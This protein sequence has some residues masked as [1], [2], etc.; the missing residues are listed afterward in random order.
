MISR[1]KTLIIAAAA[2]LSVVG[3]KSALAAP[4]DVTNQIKV[5]PTTNQVRWS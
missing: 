2:V 5:T 4:Q 1:S 3:F